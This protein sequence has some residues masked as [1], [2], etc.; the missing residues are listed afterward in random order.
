MKLKKMR[1]CAKVVVPDLM[2][3]RSQ[4]RE[5]GLDVMVLGAGGGTIITVLDIKKNPEKIL[6]FYAQT[7]NSS[8]LVSA[9]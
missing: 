1:K 3:M 6:N 4:N 2:K 7:V 8:M 5:H 9:S